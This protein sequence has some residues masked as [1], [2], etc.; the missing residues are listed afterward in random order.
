MAIIR[1]EDPASL[2][3]ERLA[4]E[5]ENAKAFEDS[6][7]KR[8]LALRELLVSALQQ[9]GE[10]DEKGNLWLSAGKFRIKYERRVS[11]SLDSAKLEEWAKENDL[12][13]QLSETVEVIVED[14]VAVLS[15]E[16]PD[17][18]PVLADFFVERSSW[19]LKVQVP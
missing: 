17:L 12:W 3:I 2:D 4:E 8:T 1:R 14:K 16:R 10:D 18:A 13:E 7:K 15:F 9:D 19:A 6:A 11:T 5:Y